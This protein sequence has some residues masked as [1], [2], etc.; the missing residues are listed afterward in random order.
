MGALILPSRFNQQPQQATQLDTSNPLARGLVHSWGLNVR[1]SLLAYDSAGKALGVFGSGTAGNPSGNTWVISPFGYCINY[2]DGGTGTV[3]SVALAVGDA[4]GS[5]SP[6]SNAFSFI[7][8]VRLSALTGSNALYA[9]ESGGIEI[10]INESGKINLLKQQTADMGSSTGAIMAGVDCDVGV[11]YDGST[12]NFYITGIPAGTS[13]SSQTFNLARQYFLGYAKG[14]SPLERIA[15]G[16]RIYRA[17]VWNRP[18]A[19]AEFKAW[20]ENPWQVYKA[21]PRR[22]LIVASAAPA[23][24]TYALPAAQ[25]S[26]AITGN[27]ASLRVAR[28]V[29]A[30]TG[31]Y[32]LIG[33]QATLQ[34][35][36]RMSANVGTYAITGVP[37]NLIKGTAP[38]A[39]QVESGTYSIAGKTVTLKVTRRM[40]AAPGSYAITGF[41]TGAPRD[42][43]G[44]RATVQYHYIPR[45]K[46][47]LVR[48]A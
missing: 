39:L 28:K 16:G 35:A 3:D 42:Y 37:A 4:N 25:G 1:G 2:F 17:D 45:S 32:S 22:M 23:G 10:R 8:K 30:S 34:V 11:S 43:S 19:P 29:A 31:T 5:G 47:T 7:A 48:F 12:V 27:P 36:R 18:L 13:S 46:L 40:T 21:P 14:T 44:F 9:S 26:Y 33:N 38:K 20:S 15:N 6:G 41:A 24:N